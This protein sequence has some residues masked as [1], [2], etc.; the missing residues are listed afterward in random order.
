MW[1]EESN[2][3]RGI[4]DT[5]IF[6]FS[7]LS[8][9]VDICTTYPSALKK[10]HKNLKSQRKLE[11]RE[12]AS[13]FSRRVGSQRIPR[14][15]A[16]RNRSTVAEWSLH[17]QAR[18]KRHRKANKHRFQRDHESRAMSVACMSA[19]SRCALAMTT[20][21]FSLALSASKLRS[22]LV[23]GAVFSF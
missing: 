12:T 15:F 21:A 10:L 18:T 20:L 23:G 6:K 4:F 13:R 7:L 3:F 2:G 16:C 19:W 9:S 5:R 11:S 14:C 17:V 1:N 22:C 8:C